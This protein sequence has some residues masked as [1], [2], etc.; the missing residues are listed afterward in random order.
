GVDRLDYTKGIDEKFLTVE[1]LLELRPDLHERVVLVQI[2]EPSRHCLAAYQELRSRLVATA[3]RINRRFGSDRWCPIIMREAHHEPAGVYQLLPAADVCH[4]GSLQDGM[5]LVAKEFVT[6]RDDERGVLILSEL[7][8]AARELP[9]ALIINPYATDACARTLGEALAMTTEE[10]RTRM[11]RLR[12][13]V[14][15]FNAY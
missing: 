7:A 14:A 9:Q 15:R 2:A 4:V 6:A 12:S 1:R 10:Q 13:L 8:G 3:A 5:N 11:R